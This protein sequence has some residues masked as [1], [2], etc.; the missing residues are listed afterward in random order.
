MTLGLL[1]QQREHGDLV[2]QMEIPPGIS[3]E[4]L[5]CTDAGLGFRPSALP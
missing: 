3:L 2:G 4:A 1:P 5:P